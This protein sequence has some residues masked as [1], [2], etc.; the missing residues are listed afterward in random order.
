MNELFT[1]TN[2]QTSQHE[3]DHMSTS[4][5]TWNHSCWWHKENKRQR[6]HAVL[7]STVKEATADKG[8]T[9]VF[10]STSLAGWPLP[11]NCCSWAHQS[12]PR[13]GHHHAGWW[14]IR[15]SSHLIAL[16][17]I[18]PLLLNVAV[19]KRQGLSKSN[20]NAFGLENTLESPANWQLKAYALYYVIHINIWRNQRLSH[21]VQ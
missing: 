11:F 9:H 8:L 1:K 21:L 10:S 20:S 2:T 19:G 12:Q 3:T 16:F 6:Q 5:L 13:R 7:S 15:T 14:W 17:C 4:S 18:F